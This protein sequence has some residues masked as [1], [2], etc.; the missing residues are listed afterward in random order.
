MNKITKT[1]DLLAYPRGTKKSKYSYKNGK[2]TPEFSTAFNKVFKRRSNWSR[3]PRL[4]ASCD[5]AVAVVMRYSGVARKYPRGRNEQIKYNPKKCKKIIYRN[6][7]PY[8]VAKDGDVI[9]YCRGNGGGHT[10]IRGS[11]CWYEAAYQKTYFHKYKDAA[12]LHRKYPKII[13]Y[14][15]K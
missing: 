6:T 13:I 14:R 15:L 3:A 8:K 4:G 5:V 12:K 1:A 10:L 9:I 7:T 11:G 2:P